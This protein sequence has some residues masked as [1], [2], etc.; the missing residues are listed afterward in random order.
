[1]SL[2]K[3]RIG[4]KGQNLTEKLKKADMVKDHK[5]IDW[6]LIETPWDVPDQM[7]NWQKRPKP[8]RKVEKCR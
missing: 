1:M 8:D 7:A 2:V 4:K 5:K 6:N 3:W